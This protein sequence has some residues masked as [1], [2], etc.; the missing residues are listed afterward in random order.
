MTPVRLMDGPPNS[1]EVV[2]VG[3]GVI[4]AATALHLA[5]A[6]L[7]PLL[8]ERRPALCSLT[9]PAS[10]GAFRLQFDNLEEL[11]VV[12]ESVELFL[13]FAEA[14]NQREYDPEVRQ[15]GY[16]W[17]TFDEARAARARRL[18]ARQHSWG[19]TDVDVLDGDEL[20]RRFPY[21]SPDA[22]LARWRAGDGFLDPKK[23]TMGMLAGAGCPA[24]VECGVTGF[25]IDGRGLSGVVTERGV[26]STRA[27]VIACGP[28]SAE[29]AARTRVDLP[30]TMVA[31]QKIVFP[32]LPIVPP[33]APMTIDDDTGAHWRPFLGGAALLFTDP[34]TAAGPPLECV[35]VDLDNVYRV[36]RPDSEVSVARVAP[37]WREVWERNADAWVVQ[38][39]QYTMSPDK[40]PLTGPTDVPGLFVNTG[41]SGHGVMTSPAISRR[42]VDVMTG[43]T[44]PEDNPFRLDREFLPREVD[45]L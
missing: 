36:L 6:G 35:P 27:A 38:T 5:R 9:T 12:R 37:F 20:R 31:R 28:F 30:V 19:L 1:A 13:N 11:E 33:G 26:V 40:R 43:A 17:V 10:T 41:D 42:L 15:Q 8:L 21:V 44:A 34:E 45:V 39:G 25:E 14:T 24:V 18:V 2:V 7:K 4:G 23:L 32:N 29:L 3:G 16:L 22:L